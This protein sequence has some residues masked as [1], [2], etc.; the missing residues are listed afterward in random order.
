MASS[1][2]CARARTNRATPWTPLSGSIVPNKLS[3]CLSLSFSIPRAL[4]L[5]RVLVGSFI[6]F[7]SNLWCLCL[8]LAFRLCRTGE[9]SCKI[10][11]CEYLATD[12]HPHNGKFYRRKP[13]RTPA[14]WW[15]ALF[16][17]DHAL[18]EAAPHTRLQLTNATLGKS[19]SPRSQSNSWN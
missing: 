10:C 18:R 6:R 7:Q 11:T 14:V 2:S 15:V 13:T 9:K 19:R 8:P 5:S 17:I 3:F 4:A 16:G 1:L 12:F